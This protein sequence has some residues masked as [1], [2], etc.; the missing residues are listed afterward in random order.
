MI[1]LRYI[2]WNLTKGWILVLL[3][4]GAVF[5]LISFIGEL[6]RITGEYDTLA[7][8]IYV[9]SILPQQMIEL[10]PVIALLGSIVALSSLD[11][12]N[13]LTVI[14][15]TGFSLRRL[16]V[17]IALPTLAL[18]VALWLAMEYAA[19]QMQQS[20]ELERR[21]LRDGDTDRLPRGGVWSTNGTYYIHILKMREGK[22]PGAISLFE[23]GEDFELLRA[24]RAREAEVGPDRK[25][26]FN[27]VR[28]KRLVNGELTTLQHKNLEIEN[29][30][31]EDELPTLALPSN[32]M[33]LSVLF[34]YAN[35]RAATGQP[36]EKYLSTFWQRLMMPLT[37]GAMVLLA[38]P[39]SANLGA[40]RG[41]SFGISIA[42]G[43]LVGILFY[44]LAQ[45]I[46][47][48]GQLLELSIPLVATL[49]SI[50]LTCCAILM[51]RRMNW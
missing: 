22:I 40:R 44:L 28:E 50:M 4:L 13:E 39:I 43:G 32:S 20:A 38:T 1:L 51:L 49:P 23:F 45:I 21:A 27:G 15:C 17:A 2:G 18:M 24:L 46:F 35:Y 25:W 34:R 19:P 26:I 14:S 29:L 48:L 7:V 5:G 6:D 47:A 36:M 10:A 11:K 9:L 31:S 41:R 16:L 12:N 33:S 37:A 8:A 42:I 3:V 30:W